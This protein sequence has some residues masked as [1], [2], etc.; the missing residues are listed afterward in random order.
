MTHT[1]N[2]EPIVDRYLAVWQV[3]RRLSG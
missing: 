1:M 2:A 3:H